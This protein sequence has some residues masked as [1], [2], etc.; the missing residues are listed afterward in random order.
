MAT[1]LRVPGVQSGPARSD[2]E[3]RRIAALVKDLN[4]PLAGLPMSNGSRHYRYVV[5]DTD[6]VIVAR[7]MRPTRAIRRSF[8]IVSK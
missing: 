5:P 3:R 8:G 6:G 4:A 7:S 2:A 1:E